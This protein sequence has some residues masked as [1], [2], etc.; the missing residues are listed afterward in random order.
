M[1]PGCLGLAPL[2]STTVTSLNITSTPPGVAG[3][4]TATQTPA[5]TEDRTVAGLAGVGPEA[6]GPRGSPGRL[7]TDGTSKHGS[8]LFHQDTVNKPS[9]DYSEINRVYYH[10]LTIISDRPSFI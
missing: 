4:V 3:G 8:L 5:I 7:D 9:V 1:L 10:L 6:G 2:L